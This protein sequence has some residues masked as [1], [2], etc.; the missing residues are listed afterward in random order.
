MTTAKPLWIAQKPPNHP[1]AAAFPAKDGDADAGVGA[2]QDQADCSISSRTRPRPQNCT[3]H[4]KDGS[5]SGRSRTPGGVA[6]S[7][8]HALGIDADQIACTVRAGGVVGLAK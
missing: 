4:F 2:R 6:A 1:A 5:L 7:V 8:A 3:A